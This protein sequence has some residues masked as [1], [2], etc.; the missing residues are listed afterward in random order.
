LLLCAFAVVALGASLDEKCSNYEKI[1]IKRG[2]RENSYRCFGEEKNGE[3]KQLSWD[4]CKHLEKNLLEKRAE[5]NKCKYEKLSIVRDSGGRKSRCYGKTKNGERK[6][7]SWDCCEELAKKLK[8][9]AEESLLEEWKNNWNDCNYE[10]LT[11]KYVR[12][13]GLGSGEACFGVGKNRERTRIN[14]EC[15]KELKKKQETKRTA[16]E[17]RQKKVQATAPRVPP[18]EVGVQSQKRRRN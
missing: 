7:L 6:Q 8:K 12:G 16:A 13:N 3:R 5:E 4:C 2:S 1:T 18:M 15:C 11:I 17:A 9:R 10:S 14:W